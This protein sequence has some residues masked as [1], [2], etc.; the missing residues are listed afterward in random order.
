MHNLFLCCIYTLGMYVHVHVQLSC[1][2]FRE[3]YDSVRKIYICPWKLLSAFVQCDQASLMI[4]VNT[5]DLG[6]I[7]HVQWIISCPCL[8]LVI[9][10]ILYANMT[11]WPKETLRNTEQER[12]HI[13]VDALKTYF[14][15]IKFWHNINITKYVYGVLLKGMPVWV[16]GGK[17][18]MMYSKECSCWAALGGT[19]TGVTR[20]ESRGKNHWPNLTAL[21][22]ETILETGVT[23]LSTQTCRT[24]TEFGH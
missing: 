3:L 5:A 23:E 19:P 10:K 4:C 16:V 20:G 15:L 8:V 18:P 13:H 1:L 14:R 7:N 12:V 17:T 9:H 2:L 22:K 6:R 24:G 21:C 11:L